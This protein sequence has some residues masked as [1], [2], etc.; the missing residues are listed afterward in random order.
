MPDEPF[1]TKGVEEA[2]KIRK[3]GLNAG[4]R[5]WNLA[6]ENLSFLYR[7]LRRFE[8]LRDTRDEHNQD[9]RRTSVKFLR[10]IGETEKSKKLIDEA[11][12]LKGPGL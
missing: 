4:H 3:Q 6:Y 10:T 12:S 2:L 11:Q 5:R 7:K 8:Q 1:R 9:C